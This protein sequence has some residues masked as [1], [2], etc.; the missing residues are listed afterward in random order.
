MREPWGHALDRLLDFGGRDSEAHAHEA[1]TFDRIEIDAWR[2]GD[3]CVTQQC[4]AE[5]QT[6]VGQV[7]HVRID[8]K[9]AVVRSSKGI[10][11]RTRAT[12]S[13]C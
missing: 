4:L 3:A 13:C 2:R 10:S 6:V 1:M 11:R 9:R 5:I 7:P 12:A 8:I